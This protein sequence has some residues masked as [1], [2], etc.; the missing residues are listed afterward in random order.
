MLAARRRCYGRV[1]CMTGLDGN[2]EGPLV[3]PTGRD[4]GDCVVLCTSCDLTEAVAPLVLTGTA[5]QLVAAGHDLVQRGLLVRVPIP[6]QPARQAVIVGALGLSPE[7]GDASATR[8]SETQR[9]V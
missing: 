3:S 6:R 8:R 9:P 1:L 4:A 7:Q 5:G 2:L